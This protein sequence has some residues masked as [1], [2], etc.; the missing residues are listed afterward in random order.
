MAT[1]HRVEEVYRNYNYPKKDLATIVSLVKRIIRI[2]KELNREIANPKEAREIL[3]L[4][5]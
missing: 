3:G 2:A 5:Q 4:N 1:F